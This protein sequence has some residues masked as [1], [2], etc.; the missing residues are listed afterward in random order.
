M[1]PNYLAIPKHLFYGDFKLSRLIVVTSNDLPE[2]E[3]CPTELAGKFSN[4]KIGFGYN[5]CRQ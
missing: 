4:L 3:D 1:N 2:T 5:L